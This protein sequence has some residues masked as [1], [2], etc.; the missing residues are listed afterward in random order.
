M[1]PRLNWLANPRPTPPRTLPTKRLWVVLIYKRRRDNLNRLTRG[2]VDGWASHV[3]YLFFALGSGQQA[4]RQEGANEHHAIIHST[5]AKHSAGHTASHTASEPHSKQAAQQASRTASKPHSKQAAQQATQPAHGQR[6]RQGGGPAERHIASKP[7]SK[8]DG[9]LDR[10]GGGGVGEG[11]S[12]GGPWNR[13]RQPAFT[14]L[15]VAAAVAALAVV[16]AVAVAAGKLHSR[17]KTHSKQATQQ[18]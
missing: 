15:L 13:R 2:C 4:R 12:A 9:Q 14:P 8:P 10:Y 11:W 3:W 1:D 18:A 17:R 7:H 6:D 5:H 16:A